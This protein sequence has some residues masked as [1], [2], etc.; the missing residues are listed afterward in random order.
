MAHSAKS[1]QSG[2]FLSQTEYPSNR[3]ISR[4]EAKFCPW[5]GYKYGENEKHCNICHQ[6]RS[7]NKVIAIS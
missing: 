7:M 5:D 3:N 4:G 6:P 1:S 2:S